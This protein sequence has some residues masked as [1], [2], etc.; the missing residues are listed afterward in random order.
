MAAALARKSGTSVGKISLPASWYSADDTSH[1]EVNPLDHTVTLWVKSCNM[2]G[3]NSIKPQCI[4][5]LLA[6]KFRTTIMNTILR[7]WVSRKPTFHSLSCNMSTGFIL[8]QDK[9]KQ[10]NER[11]QAVN[12][13]K[14]KVYFPILNFHG[15]TQSIATSSQGLSSV[16]FSVS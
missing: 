5:E 12:A 16:C 10:S 13:L 4:L 14:T 3:F 6:H 1:S 15:P 8:Q 11:A 9:L 2:P 7:S